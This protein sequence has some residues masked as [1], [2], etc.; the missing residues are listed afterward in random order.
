MSKKL[1]SEE[2]QREYWQNRYTKSV[3]STTL[4][5]TEQF[6][7]DFWRE[8]SKGEKRYRDIMKDMGYDPDVLGEKRMKGLI[9]QLRK[10]HDGVVKGNRPAVDTA[11]SKMPPEE[12]V[13]AIETELKYL[14]QEVEF[15]KKITL[16]ANTKK[17]ED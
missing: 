13:E 4:K 11:Y 5:F 6:K 16:L 14:R 8:Y 10:K 1:F 7:E 15:L 12:A 9:Y 2:Q 3:S 17:H